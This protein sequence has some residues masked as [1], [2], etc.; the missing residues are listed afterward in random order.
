M[1]GKRVPSKSNTNVTPWG[2]NCS[3]LHTV[4]MPLYCYKI[5]HTA[6]LSHL[7]VSGLVP[8][9]AVVNVCSLRSWLVWNTFFPRGKYGGHT[10][11]IQHEAGMKWQQPHSCYLISFKMQTWQVFLTIYTKWLLR[12]TT[13]SHV[14]VRNKVVFRAACSRSLVHASCS[15]S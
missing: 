8:S 15:L 9:C 10:L 14:V 3:R 12:P 11:C 7:V 13:C 4:Y 2:L 1:V 6:D 5:C